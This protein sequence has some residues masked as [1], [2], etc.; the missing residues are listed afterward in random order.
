MDGDTPEKIKARRH[1]KVLIG[2]MVVGVAVPVAL[3]VVF[4]YRAA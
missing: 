2:C 4:H 1:L 3:L